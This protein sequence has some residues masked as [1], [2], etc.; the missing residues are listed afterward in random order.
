MHNH[1]EHEHHHHDTGA[2][3][4]PA[5][6]MAT[7]PV[8]GVTIDT[9]EAEK[10]GHYRD[11]N[12]KRIYLCCA[13]CEK[14]FDENPEKYTHT[15][16]KTTELTLKE[17]EHVIDNISSFRFTSDQPFSWIPGQFIRVE[18]HH[19]NPDDEGTKRWFTIS[20]TP[21]DGFIQ[22]TTRVTSTT[23]KQALA[24]LAVGDE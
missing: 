15:P 11:Y 5:D 9:A 10:L 14:L 4:I 19:D 23:F 17:K 3:D 16:H 22:V 12:G 13:T 1:D 8:T 21:H 20:S 18:I 7:C 24:A 2:T 6:R